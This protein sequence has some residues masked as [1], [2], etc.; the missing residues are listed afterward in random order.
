MATCPTCGTQLLA[1]ADFCAG[2]GKPLHAPPPEPSADVVPGASWPV[3]PVQ[4]EIP[5]AAAPGWAPPPGQ[6]PP[7]YAPPG[8]T[9]PGAPPPA[10][11]PPGYAPNYYAQQF[12]SGNPPEYLDRLPQ[13]N[14]GAFFFP[15]FWALSHR[16]YIWALA[17]FCLGCP[18]N[19][20]LAIVGNKEAW[21]AR[22]FQSLDQ[23]SQV[24]RAWAMAAAILVGILAMFVMQGVIAGL[25][26]GR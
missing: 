21:K 8:Y 1:G 17:A 10:Y 9:V 11:A 2:C 23:F 16:L 22:P 7:A 13:W 15:F 14:W 24:Q 12:P 20:V 18:L 4:Q 3:G 19:I 5:P 25:V 26:N 6:G